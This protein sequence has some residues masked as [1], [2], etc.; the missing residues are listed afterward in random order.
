MS[1]CYSMEPIWL[2]GWCFR[3]T[4]SIVVGF[5][6]SSVAVHFSTYIATNVGKNY[7]LSETQA[8]ILYSLKHNVHCFI[9]LTAY[10]RN[11]LLYSVRA[12]TSDWF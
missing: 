5:G 10:L 3:L 9:S 4:G 7:S 11:L 6:Q 12:G 2:S 1:W 8:I